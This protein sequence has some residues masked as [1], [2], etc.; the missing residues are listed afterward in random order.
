M[1][2]FT[3]AGVMITAA[4]ALAAFTQRDVRSSGPFEIGQPVPSLFLPDSADGRSRSLAEFRGRRSFFTS[5]RPGERANARVI[6]S[7]APCP[8]ERVSSFAGTSKPGRLHDRIAPG[9]GDYYL[10]RQ[11]YASQQTNE[12]IDPHRPDNLWQPIPGDRGAHGIFDDRASASSLQL[13]ANTNRLWFAVAGA[14]TAA[15][16][17][18]LTRK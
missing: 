15:C 14:A 5:F 10:G 3:T 18:L 13:W 17:A 11:G 8:G 1:G 7:A 2:I 9:L 4:I 12:P 6:S 16:A